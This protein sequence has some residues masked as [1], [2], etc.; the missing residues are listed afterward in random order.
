MYG[1][2]NEASWK[3]HLIFR[4]AEFGKTGRRYMPQRY[5]HGRW[6]IFFSQSNDSVRLTVSHCSI[7][8]SGN[9]ENDIFPGVAVWLG[10]SGE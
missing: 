7:A 10:K 8:L 3:S 1:E 2:R 9:D 4:E 6:R 5:P